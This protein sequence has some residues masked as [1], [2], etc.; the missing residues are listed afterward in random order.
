MVK[1]K[2][3][4]SMVLDL[5]KANSDDSE[6]TEEH[7][8]HLASRCRSF[9]LKQRYYTDLKKSIPDSNYQTICVNLVKAEKIEGVPCIGYYLCSSEAIP[10]LMT[11][12]NTK[13][14]VSDNYFNSD[15]TFVSRNRFKYIDGNKWNKHII[16]ATTGSDNKMYLYSDNPQFINIKNISIYGIFENAESSSLLE[17]KNHDICDIMDMDF[18]LEDSL[19][20]TLI[21]LVIQRVAPSITAPEDKVN[22]ANDDLSGI[23]KQNPEKRVQTS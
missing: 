13:V 16:Y 14:F 1:Y 8:I 3:I 5:L 17:C 9:L 6:L 10:T 12:G 2:E 7:I 11:F 21:D 23:S 19:I 22:N 18:P 20:S 15:I 4:V